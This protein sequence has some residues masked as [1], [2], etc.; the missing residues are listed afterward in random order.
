MTSKHLATLVVAAG[1]VI[2]FFLAYE[3][4]AEHRR[5]IDKVR[6]FGMFG[7]D[8]LAMS[9]EG[10][11]PAQIFFDQMNA[12]TSYL[13]EPHYIG[14]GIALAVPL[15]GNASIQPDDIILWCKGDILHAAS[16]SAQAILPKAPIC[17]FPIDI[18]VFRVEE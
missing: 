15:M 18:G 1:L 6:V 8:A 14:G 13:S 12:D 17:P 5:V 9:E 2:V 7:L 3:K 16:P 4:Y 10:V 11:K